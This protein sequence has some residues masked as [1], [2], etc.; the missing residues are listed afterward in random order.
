M[1]M[2]GRRLRAATWA[3]I[4]VVV[5]ARTVTAASTADEK[6]LGRKFALE[7]RAKLPLIDDVQ[8]NAYVNRVGQKVVAALGEQPFQYQFFV[9]RDPRINA[10]AVPGGY[11]YV[12]AGLLTRASN[13]DEL[14]GVL[15]HEVAHVYAHHL[16][17]QQEATQLMNYATLLG[18]L[19][20]ALQPAIGAGAIAAN[21]AM[22]LH[23]RRE[24]EQEADYTGARI[25]QAAGYDPR[26]M[27]D[28]FKKMLDEQRTTPT[29]AP[30]YLLSHPLTEARLTNLEAVLHTHQWDRGPR[31]PTSLELERVQLLTRAASEPAADVV[32]WYHRHADGDATSGRARYL[33]GLAYLETGAYDSARQSLE[34]AQRLGFA[35]VDRELGRTYLRMRQPEKAREFLS[36]ATE[37]DPEDALAHQELAKVLESQNDSAGAMR[38]YERA[39]QLAPSLQEAHYGLGILAGRAGQ[40]G[41]GFY[42]LGVAFKLRGEFDKALSQFEKAEPLLPSNTQRAQDVHAQ[43][44]ELSEYLGRAR[45]HSR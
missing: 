33:L 23:Y 31:R 13:D 27:L 19:L 24:F 38:E 34:A 35:D 36:R 25:M 2:P 44:A 12:H 42:H 45:P 28:F 21:A 4:C 22:Q 37:V 32:T 3:L 8:V 9:V 29:F 30:P 5:W 1:W 26:G 10:F 43:I 7:A 39:L 15:G 18:V 17:R 20:S 14:A 41:D 16:A 6:E 40:R 11:I